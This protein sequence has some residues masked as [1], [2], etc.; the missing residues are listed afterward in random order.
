MWRPPDP[1]RQWGADIEKPRVR[2]TSAF[3]RAASDRRT[4]G[5][6]STSS[7]F[8]FRAVTAS[9][10]SKSRLWKCCTDHWIS[11]SR[12]WKGD[13]CLVSQELPVADALLPSLGSRVGHTGST[14]NQA[15]V[16]KFGLDLTKNK[17][18]QECSRVVQWSAGRRGASIAHTST[19]SLASSLT[20]PMSTSA[21]ELR[22]LG[23]FG[24]GRDNPHGYEYIAPCFSRSCPRRIL[25]WSD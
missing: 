4:V 1:H 6:P 19:A 8:I 14:V 9:W 20:T 23:T 10:I 25:Q 18:R 21:I 15:L 7:A 5:L 11:K 12:L 3:G 24:V 2:E 17:S 13:R 22:A 16:A